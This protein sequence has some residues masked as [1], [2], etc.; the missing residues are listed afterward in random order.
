MTVL[1]IVKDKKDFRG[2]NHRSGFFSYVQTF[3]AIQEAFIN[4]G[5]LD[6]QGL[7][8]CEFKRT[9]RPR[10]RVRIM[11]GLAWYRA[12]DAPLRP[13]YVLVWGVHAS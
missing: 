13:Y 5:L 9:Q 12:T 2:T 4:S 8:S 6:C 7:T 11:I 1:L 10:R 3:R